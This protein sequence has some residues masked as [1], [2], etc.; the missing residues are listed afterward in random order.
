[1]PQPTVDP[2][3]LTEYQL[4]VELW[5]HD[6]TMRQSRNQMLMGLNSA[7]LVVLGLLF[8]ATKDQGIRGWAGVIAGV[9]GFAVCWVW[10]IVQARHRQY[11]NFHGTKLR[12]LE[13]KLP[14]ST[15]YEMDRAFN[16]KVQVRLAPAQTWFQV[17]KPGHRSSADA[18]QRLPTLMRVA[19]G[20][21]VVVSLVTLIF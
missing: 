7:V 17:K 19:W 10:A 6:D 20:A 16:E 13:T 18:E 14:F 3:V 21:T 2:A 12:S 1:M 15:F 11:L 9:F 4:N 5:K 8:T